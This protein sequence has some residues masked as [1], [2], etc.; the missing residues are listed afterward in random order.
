M[1]G[2]CNAADPPFATTFFKGKMDTS[3]FGGL[4]KS[5]G[6]RLSCK[7]Q[8]A[9]FL[10]STQPL[11]N[12]CLLR[13]QE[14]FFPLGHAK[15]NFAANLQILAAVQELPGGD[16]VLPIHHIIVTIPEA[17]LRFIGNTLV[18]FSGNTSNAGRVESTLVS[19]A[20]ND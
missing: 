4:L 3:Q 18:K 1:V 8:G 7:D 20:R 13:K 6:G 11:G 14:G 17:D 19:I 2:G 9:E 5:N 10:P 12:A 16:G 15:I